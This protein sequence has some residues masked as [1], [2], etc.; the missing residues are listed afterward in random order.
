MELR[1]IDLQISDIKSK[2]VALI[3]K[4]IENNIKNLKSLRRAIKTN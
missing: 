1:N 2:S 3:D 4:K